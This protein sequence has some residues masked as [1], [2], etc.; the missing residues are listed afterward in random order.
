MKTYRILVVVL[1]ALVLC[2]GYLAL[3]AHKKPETE[4]AK[5]MWYTNTVEK[6]QTNTVEKWFT[7]TLGV[8]RSTTVVEPV[9]NEVIKIKEVPAKLSDLERRA[10]TV[11][12]KYI[13]APLLE[14]STDAL[15]KASPLAVQ[16]SLDESA[17]KL[18]TEDRAAIKKQIEAVL[19]SRSIPVAEKSTHRLKLNIG[20]QWQTDVPDVSLLEYELELKEDVALQRQDDAIRCAGI[21]WRSL[22]YKLTREFNN[23]EDLNAALREAIGKFCD[24]Y[25]KAKASEKMVESRI[26]SIPSDFLAGGR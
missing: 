15:Y 6:W 17:S 8:S 20:G 12:Y 24:D 16:V 22:T 19:Q 14:N 3:S 21:V 26:P 5:E 11:G 10:A 18:V 9:T 13:N 1:S 25:L 23:A 4:M 2:L 7:N